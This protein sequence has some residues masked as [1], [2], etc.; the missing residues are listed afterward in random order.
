MRLNKKCRMAI[1]D[2]NVCFYVTTNVVYVASMRMNDICCI[3]RNLLVH[4]EDNMCF[5]KKAKQQTNANPNLKS[6]TKF[7]NRKKGR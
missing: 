5:V 7:T 2:C 1:F 6:N 4:K 3:L